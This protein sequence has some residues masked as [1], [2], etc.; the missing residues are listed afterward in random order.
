MFTGIIEEIGT[1]RRFIPR[2][3]RYDLTI[4]AENVT[5]G[6]AVDHSIGVNGVCLSVTAL[7]PGGFHAQVVPQTVSM[8]TMKHLRAGARVNL[9]RAVPAGG[10]FGGHFVQGHV[11]GTA[12]VETLDRRSDHALLRLLLPAGL[13]RY[14]VGQGSVCVDGVSLTIAAIHGRRVDAAVIPHT[15]NRTTL[16]ERKRGDEVNVEVDLLSKYVRRHLDQGAG[17]VRYA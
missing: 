17:V 7:E 5:E 11:D 9:E 4:T 2:S 13:L 10:R 14:C 12:R 3:G 8:S 15:M 1:V 6:L 16:G